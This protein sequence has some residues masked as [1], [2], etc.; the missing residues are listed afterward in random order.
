MDHDRLFK[1]LLRTFFVEF[2]AAFVPN[3]SAFLDASTIEFLDK[4]VFTD[5][6]SSD[7]HE[8][9]LLVKARFKG[10]E[11]FFLIHV[12]NQA[13]AQ[14][15]FAARM[16]R[17]FA[18]LNEKH[19]LPVYPI[20]L[21][22]YDRPQRPEPNRYE[23]VFP[24]L[25]VLAFEFQAI[26]LNRLNWRDY[27]RNP[28][29]VAAALM[30]KMKIEPQDRPRMALECLRMIATLRLDPARQTLV[31]SFMY[32]YLDLSAAELKVYNRELESI[33]CPRKKP[34]CR[35]SILGSRKAFVSAKSAACAAVK[36][37][38]LLAFSL[39]ALGHWPSHFANKSRIY[40]RK[41]S[42]NWPMQSWNLRL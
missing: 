19:R 10:E 5:V 37:L 8:V 21:L 33:R 39:A 18:R 3:V 12:E 23:V 20:A 24:G 34:L 1:E 6:A 27:L 16:F 42:N 17:Y 4:E 29:P 32:A 14:E 15:D 36:P 30:T 38:S 28:N 22:S 41:S 11:A 26:H 13:T 7:R 40:L 35:S 2:I 25:N 31:S 9:D